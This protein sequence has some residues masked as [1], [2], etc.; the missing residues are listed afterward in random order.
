MGQNLLTFP[1]HQSSPW[2]F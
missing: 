2:V 1:K